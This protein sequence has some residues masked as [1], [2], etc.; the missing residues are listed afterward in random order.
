MLNVRIVF[1]VM[2]GLAYEAVAWES[3]VNYSLQPVFYNFN[4]DSLINSVSSVAEASDVVSD[5][6]LEVSAWTQHLSLTTTM[7][8][9]VKSEVS[10][11]DFT[12]KE[13]MYTTDM[14][15]WEVSLGKKINSWGVGMA[16]RPLDILQAE[17]LLTTDHE[18]QA[19]VNQI[20]IERYGDTSSSGIYWAHLDK[21]IN[22]TSL[23][24]RYTQ[25]EEQSDWQALLGYSK[26]CALQ[27]GA[28][29]SYILTDALELHASTLFL[30]RYRKSLYLPSEPNNAPLSN[31]YSWKQVQ[32]SE[33]GNGMIGGNYTWQNKHNLLFEYWHNSQAWT[34]S[35]WSNHLQIIRRR[36]ALQS[37]SNPVRIKADDLTASEEWVSQPYSVQNNF[38]YAISIKA[39]A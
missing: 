21:P 32:F 39:L 13:L 17:D 1:C 27:V 2:F 8:H 12:I 25:S 22:Q 35:Q 7:R 10:Q 31:T 14:A 38:F 15:D 6:L 3:V 24:L 37:V 29:I 18:S 20:S 16:Y 9:N 26:Q 19:G 5:H 11:Y 4:E 23:V 33:G 30:S 34:E 28:G 36:L